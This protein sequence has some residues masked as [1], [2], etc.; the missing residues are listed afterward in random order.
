VSRPPQAIARAARAV[1]SEAVEWTA[2]ARG[3]TNAERW[4][5]RLRGGG[6]TFVKAAVDKQTAGWLE[7]EYRVYSAIDRGYL[8]RLLGWDGG[9]RPVLVLEDLSSA[10]WPPPWPAGAVDAVLATLGEVAATPAP[11]GLPR[12][13]DV[14][15]E[16]RGWTAVGDE[17]APFLSLELYSE[18]W[19][20]AALPTLT[21]A[22][23]A[24]QLAGDALLHCDVRSDN[25]CLRAG[26]ALLV[27]WNLA[28]V[29]NP[30]ADVAFWLPSLAAEDGALPEDVAPG[31]PGAPELAA[32][33]AGFFAVR[34]GLPPPPTAPTVRS[35]QLSQLRVALPWA[36]RQLGLPAPV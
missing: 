34:A 26:R 2:V 14:W 6:S 17:P 23:S 10:E 13:E 28:V 25:V 27:D 5:M 8:P 36:A 18:R 30:A 33:I 22:E 19:L 29:G 20:D 24:A 21:A 31:L 11:A 4:H 32:L 16:P 1:G 12:L 7:T 9:E 35:L 3:Y 15:D